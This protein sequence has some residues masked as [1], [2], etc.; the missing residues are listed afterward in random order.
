[1]KFTEL[2]FPNVGDY[3]KVGNQKI[4]IKKLI[5]ANYYG[6]L[7]GWYVEFLSS[8]GNYHYWKQGLDGGELIYAE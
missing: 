5:T 2:R 7:D 6:E 3:I 4:R 8:N 1:M